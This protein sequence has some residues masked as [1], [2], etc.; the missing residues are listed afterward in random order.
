M[1]K[2]SNFHDLKKNCKFAILE[3]GKIAIKL[4]KKI[5]VK[6][7]SKNQPVTNADIEINDYLYNFF[8]SETLILVGYQRNQLMINLDLKMII[9]GVR[10]HRWDTFIYFQQAEYIQYL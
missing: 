2:I 9:T 3:A 4:Q 8:Q 1:K 6:Y 7:K 10:S 5:N